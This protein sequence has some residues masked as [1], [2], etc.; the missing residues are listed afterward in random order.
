MSEDEG[1]KKRIQCPHWA[2]KRTILNTPVAFTFPTL[3]NMQAPR[4]FFLT[5]NLGLMAL[6]PAILADGDWHTLEEQY[7]N[8]PAYHCF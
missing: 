2:Q 7:C 8:D 3:I 4:V 5:V 1:Y 6:V